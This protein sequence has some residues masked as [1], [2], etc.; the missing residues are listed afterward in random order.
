MAKGGQR[1]ICIAITAIS[2]IAL[3]LLVL[4]IYFAVSRP[5]C[6]GKTSFFITGDV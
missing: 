2:L 6:E 5:D 4:T 3:V 1:P